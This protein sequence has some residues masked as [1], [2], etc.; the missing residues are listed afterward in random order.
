MPDLITAFTGISNT[1]PIALKEHVRLAVFNFI[2]DVSPRVSSLLR[3]PNFFFSLLSPYFVFLCAHFLSPLFFR[4]H[5]FTVLHVSLDFLFPTVP[6]VIFFPLTL[7]PY[8]ILA[9]PREK[10]YAS[11]PHFSCSLYRSQLRAGAQHCPAVGEDLLAA[12]RSFHE[13]DT[14]RVADLARKLCDC[15][16]AVFTNVYCM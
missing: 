5:F 7:F 14:S 15:H 6:A 3:G 13:R 11:P 12:F 16:L 2:R 10:L 1:P 8:F 4:P 9:S